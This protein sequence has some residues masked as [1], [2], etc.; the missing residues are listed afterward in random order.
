MSPKSLKLFIQFFIKTLV[1]FTLT[2]SLAFAQ[3]P[4]KYNAPSA[5]TSE[6]IKLVEKYEILYYQ[7]ETK[8]SHAVFK[9]LF[10]SHKES[11]PLTFLLKHAYL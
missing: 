3:S 10:L 11:I 5:K 7:G 9:E 8:E 1:S 6:A 2:L 4:Q